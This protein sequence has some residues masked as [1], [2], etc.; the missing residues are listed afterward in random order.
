ML[1]VVN[2]NNNEEVDDVD[3]HDNGEWWEVVIIEDNI[4]NNLADDMKIVIMRIMI[5]KN[6]IL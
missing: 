1:Y 5:N 4:S 6:K 3:V 2:N